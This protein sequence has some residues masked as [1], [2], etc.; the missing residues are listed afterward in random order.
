M[1]L[2]LVT[3]PWTGPLRTYADYFGPDSPGAQPFTGALGQ[4]QIALSFAGGAVAIPIGSRPASASSAPSLFVASVGTGNVQASATTYTL[5]VPPAP[6]VP[7]AQPP[8]VAGNF[9][10]GDQIRFVFTKAQLN[11]ANVTID[12]TGPVVVTALLNASVGANGSAYADIQ[13]QLNAAGT[14]YIWAWVAGGYN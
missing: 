11:G 14:A 3:N 13:L 6:T 10:P 7:A 2:S 5:G 12:Y 1:T 8:V 9:I 4:N